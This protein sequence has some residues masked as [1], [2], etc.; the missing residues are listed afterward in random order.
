MFLDDAVANFKDGLGLR[1]VGL[2]MGFK[3]SFS[4]TPHISFSPL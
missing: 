2:L 3:D 1:L 4:S